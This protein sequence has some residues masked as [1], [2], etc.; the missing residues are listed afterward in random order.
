MSGFRYSVGTSYKCLKATQIFFLVFKFSQKCLSTFKFGA[1]QDSFVF[2]PITETTNQ[3]SNKI[4]S[5]DTVRFSVD[6]LLY[7]ITTCV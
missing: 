4:F 7:K 3:I 2:S 1:T 5:L 6:F